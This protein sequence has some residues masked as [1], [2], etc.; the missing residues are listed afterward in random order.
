MKE[1]LVKNRKDSRRAAESLEMR[2]KAVLQGVRKRNL[3]SKK[4]K[5]SA[6]R[7]AVVGARNGDLVRNRN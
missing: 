2:S 3:T 5:L 7:K 4:Q 6:K 1:D